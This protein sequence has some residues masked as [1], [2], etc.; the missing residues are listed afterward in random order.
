M[1]TVAVSHPTISFLGSSS[2][3]IPLDINADK[4]LAAANQFISLGLKDVGYE[5]VNIDVSNLFRPGDTYRTHG[6]L[7][8]LAFD[9]A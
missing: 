8:L 9:E 6:F 3:S 2:Q 4:V 1:P 7:G 5:Y